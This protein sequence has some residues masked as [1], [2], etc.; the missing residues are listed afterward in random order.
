MLIPI[1]Y[2]GYEPF[3]GEEL[4]TNYLTDLIV[5]ESTKT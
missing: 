1:L 3:L 5:L 4:V 2:L